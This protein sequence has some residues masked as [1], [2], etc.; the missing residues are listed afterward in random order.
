[1]SPVRNFST[2]FNVRSRR[3]LSFQPAR[4]DLATT[5]C[6]LFFPLECQPGMFYGSF[7][8]PNFYNKIVGKTLC[9]KTSYKQKQSNTT[10]R[11]APEKGR[12]GLALKSKTL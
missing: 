3:G 10:F 5:F 1:M 9:Q 12:G 11:P 2:E 4:S 7:L 6:E 8:Q